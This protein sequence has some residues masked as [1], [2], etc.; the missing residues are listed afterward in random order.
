LG[1]QQLKR[2]QAEVEALVANMG[3]SE[4]AEWNQEAEGVLQKVGR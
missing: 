1:P 4:P 3:L 2:L